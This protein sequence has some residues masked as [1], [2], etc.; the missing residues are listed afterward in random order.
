MKKFFATLIVTVTLVSCHDFDNQKRGNGNVTT[1][2]REVTGNFSKIVVGQA[3]D[4]EIE[5]ADSYSIEVETDSN[6]QNHIKTT[7]E[8][9]V[10]KISSDANIQDAEKL[11]VRIKMKQVTEIETTSAS[12]V[13]S[14]NLLKGKSLR[15]AASSSSDVEIEAE[16][17]TIHL[18]ATSTGE[19]TIKGKTLKLETSA[20]SA[21]EIDASD[22]LA[23]EVFAQATSAS[24]TKVYAIVKLD[25]K[26]ASAGSITSVKKPKEVRKE[27]T[28]GGEVSIE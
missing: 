28:S 26:A 21:S 4:V 11:L 14:V 12:S 7:V 2:T 13:Q 24:D 5:Q 27:E 25:A 22:L 10:L 1:D 16:Y 19:I 9:G 20:S 23:N 15:I 8:N 6:L 3:I 17:E 18:E